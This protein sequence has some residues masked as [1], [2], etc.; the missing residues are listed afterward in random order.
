MTGWEVLD[1]AVKIGLGAAIAA[2]FALFS[3]NLKFNR[4]RK[5]IKFEEKRRL[6]LKVAEQIDLAMQKGIES[7]HGFLSGASSKKEE[8]RQLERDANV[9]FGQAYTN[10][11]LSGYAKLAESVRKLNYC[12]LEHS[13]KFR[14]GSIDYDTCKKE[15]NDNAKLFEK[16]IANVYSEFV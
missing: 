6:V 2:G 14:D 4:N 3:D 1:T 8:F 15:I 5:N 16:Q 7:H 12:Y 10:A 13:A 9:L 11:N